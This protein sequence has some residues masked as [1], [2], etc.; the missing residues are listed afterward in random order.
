[1]NILITGGASGLGEA[2]TRLL[3]EDKKNFIYFTY[4]RSELNAKKIEA[5]F[6][7]T[8]SIQC[9][10]SDDLSLKSLID[11]IQNIDLDVLINNAYSGE[12]SPIHF[13]K[14]SSEDFLNDFENNIIPTIKITQGVLKNFRKKR[15]GR[16]ITIL[17]S[18]LVNSPPIGLS[19]YVANKAYI[20]ELTK[21]WAIEN[22][23]FNISSNSVSPSFMQT[24]MTKNIDERLV[25]QIK[26]NHPLKEL[27]TVEEVAKTVL[28][29]VHATPHI[30]GVDIVINAGENIK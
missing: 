26:E 9:D 29:L 24:N 10:F 5:E 15:R 30:N 4:N 1:M 6:K 2:I 25:K 16:I 20:K 27:L 17:T 21:I 19:S 23:K 18:F 8:N 13:H 3:A 22:A 12:V 11:Y 14:I 28:F 7:N